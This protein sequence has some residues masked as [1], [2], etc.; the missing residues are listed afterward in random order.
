MAESKEFSGHTSGYKTRIPHIPEGTGTFELVRESC[1]GVSLYD[2]GQGP[3]AAM[4]MGD[5]QERGAMVC[6]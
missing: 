6:M 4:V 2:H 1:E 5:W 3:T